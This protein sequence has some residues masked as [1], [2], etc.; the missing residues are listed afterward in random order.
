MAEALAYEKADELGNP[1]KRLTVPRPLN[2]K[3]S[4][5][6]RPSGKQRQFK[7]LRIDHDIVVVSSDEDDLNYEATECSDT[8]DSDDTADSWW[9]G[10]VAV[11]PSN[12][13]VCL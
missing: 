4:A 9:P 7:T 8:C 13:E 1:I 6:A 2:E 12:A 10:E 5:T 3:N 11:L